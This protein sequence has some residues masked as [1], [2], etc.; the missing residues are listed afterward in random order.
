[1][2]LGSHS[3]SQNRTSPLREEQAKPLREEQAK[4]REEGASAPSVSI[5][6][7]FP[8][9]LEGTAHSLYRQAF[10]QS[11]QAAAI[12]ERLITDDRMSLVWK[13]LTKR[14]RDP[15]DI[16][17]NEPVKTFKR[18]FVPFWGLDEPLPQCPGADERDQ[19]FAIQAFFRRIANY[20][21]QARPIPFREQGAFDRGR[22]QDEAT[23]LRSDAEIVRKRAAEVARL[24]SPGNL[25]REEQLMD[26]VRAVTVLEGLA[27]ET[28]QE[29]HDK[30]SF[31]AFVGMVGAAAKSLFGT[32]LVNTTATI[33]S[34]VFGREVAPN[35]VREI[36]RSLGLSLA[37]PK[38]RKAKSPQPDRDRPA[39]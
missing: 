25:R 24:V 36:F 35:R 34:V 14:N 13:E 3:G 29:K 22:H 38:S 19:R 10:K 37:K 27:D 30:R 23:S 28:D 26:L 7:W 12:V 20:A 21:V 2:G 39:R 32:G 15:N 6:P 1:M 18:Q 11:P 4:L 16:Q 5:P 17:I 31:K 33:A 8:C 9:H